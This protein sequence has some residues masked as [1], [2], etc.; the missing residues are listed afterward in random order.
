[1]T[2]PS[3]YSNPYHLLASDLVALREAGFLSR[4][5]YISKV[6]LNDK[7]KSD[8]F[9][10]LIAIVQSLW[11]IVQIIVRACHHLAI[12]QLEIAVAAFAVCAVVIYGLNWEKPKGVQTPYTLLAYR[13]DIPK[14]V[15]ETVGKER[16]TTDSFLNDI[17]HNFTV[18]LS[19][20]QHHNDRAPG[21][22]VPNHFSSTNQISTIKYRIEDERLHEVVGLL[23]GGMVFG[24]IHL[25]AW[26]FV[27]PTLLERKLWWVASVICTAG[28]LSLLL[29]YVLV[30]TL[31]RPGF[32]AVCVFI[33]VLLSPLYIV[34]R[35]FLL[36]EVFRTLCFLP[37]SAY[38][39]TWAGNVPHIA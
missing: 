24:A 26:D 36:V 12:S 39:A 3:E 33:S 31:E 13:G 2:P 20:N 7:S 25:A 30:Y 18:L 5:P 15:L 22:P 37:P 9:V 32:K 4:L 29:D 34:A 17:I 21:S 16:S 27:F 35:L 14:A 19:F 28:P 38:V 6:E 10:R 1:M 23:V 11:M 8:S